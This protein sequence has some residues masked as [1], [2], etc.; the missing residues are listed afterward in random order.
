[1]AV[2]PMSRAIKALEEEAACT[3][4]Y[5]TKKA[6]SSTGFRASGQLRPAPGSGLFSKEQLRSTAHLDSNTAP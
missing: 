2:A 4:L 5:A 3:P 1:M 6:G